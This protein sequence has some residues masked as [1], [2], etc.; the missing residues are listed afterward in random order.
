VFTIMSL[1]AHRYKLS[2][3]VMYY[4]SFRRRAN[5]ALAPNLAWELLTSLYEAYLWRNQSRMAFACCAQAACLDVSDELR[6]VSLAQTALTCTLDKELS[7]MGRHL[8]DTA[9]GILASLTHPS[10]ESVYQIRLALGLRSSVFCRWKNA[11]DDLREAQIAARLI[12]SDHHICTAGLFAAQNALWRAD[13]VSANQELAEIQDKGVISSLS[14]NMSLYCFYKCLRIMID[15]LFVQNYLEV[16]HQCDEILLHINDIQS[17]AFLLIYPL[18]ALAEC[19]ICNWQIADVYCGEIVE[20]IHHYSDVVPW[21]VHWMPLFI[22]RT[23]LETECRGTLLSG[24]PHRF[25]ASDNL[26]SRFQNLLKNTASFPITSAQPHHVMGLQHLANGNQKRAVKSLSKA[27]YFCHKHDLKWELVRAAN[28]LKSADASAISPDELVAIN[29]IP[30]D[31]RECPG[32]RPLILRL[33]R[34]FWMRK[35]IT[36]SAFKRIR[37]A[38]TIVFVILSLLVCLYAAL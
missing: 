4:V 5:A 13:L 28:D 19:K 12:G 2:S 14:Q 29:S 16:K 17:L 23:I 1:I 6:A 25:I 30:A 21:M 33:E 8:E 9:R 34:Q 32:S 37:S 35:Y 27:I 11:D 10:Q 18:L 22:G 31:F 24:Q 3:R 15:Y 20:R 36:S 38:F 26:Y 7:W